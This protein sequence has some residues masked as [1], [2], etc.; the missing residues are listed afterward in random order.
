MHFIVI[1]AISV[2]GG[3]LIAGGFVGYRRSLTT[4]AKVV[5]A[6]GVAAGLVMWAVLLLIVPVS[7]NTETQPQ[8][9]VETT[10]MPDP[11]SG[12]AGAA[13]VSTRITLDSFED[14]LTLEDIKAVSPVENLDSEITDYKEQAGQVDPG[15]V[16]DMRRWYG[17][18]VSSRGGNPGLTMTVIDFDSV[19]AASRHYEFVAADDLLP[20]DT[21]VGDLSALAEFNNQ[22][23]GSM[24]VFIQGN[25][26]V[27][28]HTTVGAG[29]L[30][31]MTRESLVEMATLVSDRLE[32]D[33]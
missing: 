15:Q 6:A 33:G 20:M 18:T 11:A 23:I 4:G 29:Q 25:A 16:Q 21:T 19:A 2:L 27:S 24:L 13:I 8:P 3:A 9:I 30:P 12:S 10:V 17:F 22:G 14:L 32:T 26:M 1:I 28:L 5:S 31:L 7:S